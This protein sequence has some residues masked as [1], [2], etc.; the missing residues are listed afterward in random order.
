MA[1]ISGCVGSSLCVGKDTLHGLLDEH[2]WDVIGE[3][4]D[5]GKKVRFHVPYVEEAGGICHFFFFLPFLGL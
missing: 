1:M 5:W 4:I 2:Y 3:A